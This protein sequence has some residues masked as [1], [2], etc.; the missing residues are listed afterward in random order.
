MFSEL[1]VPFP[2]F[3]LGC[4]AFDGTNYY[5]FIFDTTRSPKPCQRF[6]KFKHFSSYHDKA[7][8]LLIKKV[9][10]RGFGFKIQT[11]WPWVLDKGYWNHNNLFQTSQAKVNQIGP[12]TIPLRELTPA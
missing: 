7:P 10:F 6:L 9:L 2:E 11:K 5:I 8:P 3:K 4:V 12:I 1:C